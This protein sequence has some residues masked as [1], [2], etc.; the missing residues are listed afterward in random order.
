MVTEATSW[1][2]GWSLQLGGDPMASIP[3]SEKPIIS[4]SSMLSDIISASHGM[5]APQHLCRSY[6]KTKEVLYAVYATRECPC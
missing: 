2:L 5:K 4:T 6:K 1:P 3:N